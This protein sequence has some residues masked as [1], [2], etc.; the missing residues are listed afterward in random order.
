VQISFE[1]G[2]QGP[3]SAELLT[4]Q[5]RVLY[6]TETVMASQLEIPVAEQPDGVYLVRVAVA[7]RVITRKVVKIH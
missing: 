4:V 7:D 2:L 1:D 3:R 5:G 6:R